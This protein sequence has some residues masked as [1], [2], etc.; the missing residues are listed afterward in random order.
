[1]KGSANDFKNKLMRLDGE[2]GIKQFV[3]ILAVKRGR[4]ML[5]QFRLWTVKC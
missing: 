2:A 1:M 4:F 5:P 3:P